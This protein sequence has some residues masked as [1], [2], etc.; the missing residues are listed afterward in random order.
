MERQASRETSRWRNKLVRES[1]C[2]TGWWRDRPVEGQADGRTG[3]W[4]DR[5]VKGPA[6]RGEGTG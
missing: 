5:L 6:G 2:R 3:W 1:G 4:R